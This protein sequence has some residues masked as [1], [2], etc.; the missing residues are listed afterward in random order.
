MRRATK[1][2]TI[3]A[4]AAVLIAAAIGFV[5]R[6]GDGTT[7]RSGNVQPLTKASVRRQQERPPPPPPALQPVAIVN[8]ATLKVRIP[9]GLSQQDQDSYINDEIYRFRMLQLAHQGGVTLT[10]EEIAQQRQREPTPQQL[11]GYLAAE[12][13]TL[14][15][16]QEQQNQIALIQKMEQRLVFSK[17]EVPDA[18]VEAAFASHPE[19]FKQDR[20]WAWVVFVNGGLSAK[21]R[22]LL[23][24]KV[25]AGNWE[26]AKGIVGA[27]VNRVAFNRDG[28]VT[29]VQD[30]G[31]GA[32]DV[33]ALREPALPLSAEEKGRL[34]ETPGEVLGPLAAS[35]GLLWVK[36]DGAKSRSA[37]VLAD[38]R[39]EVEA[40][41]RAQR[42]GEAMA[43]WVPKVVAEAQVERL[44]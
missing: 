25:R 35:G 21:Q 19:Q 31:S 20:A 44:Q 32:G 9:R 5:L 40:Y 27:E 16:F 22:A 15:A 7:H 34:F 3:A 18:D 12:G 28:I 39:G 1:A 43:K 13:M 37:I 29:W 10:A 24:Q 14:A 42:G 36:G 38:V 33:P 2:G 26:A 8:G 11:Q 30:S 23:D 4:L 17:I 6:D 41:L